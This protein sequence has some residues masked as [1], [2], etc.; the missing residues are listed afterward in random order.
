MECRPAL[1]TGLSWIAAA[2]TAATLH[3][4]NANGEPAYPERPVRILVPFPPGQTVDIVG[5]IIGE[6]FTDAFGKQ[7][8]VDNRAGAGGTIGTALAARAVPDGYTLVVV[9]NGTLAGNAALW[10]DKL[11]YKATKDFAPIINF[12]A[13]PQL[14]VSSP[15]SPYKTVQDLVS[16]AKANPGKLNY[17]LPG[18]GNSSHLAMEM[19]RARAGIDINPVPYNGSPA[20]FIDIMAGRI[21]VMFEAASGVLV[22]VKSGKI[23]AIATGGP[24]RAVFLPDV[25][26]VAESGYPG[27][28]A[29][30]WVGLAAPAGTPKAIVNVLYHE[31]DK[32]L[33]TPEGK[34]RIISMGMEPLGMDPQQ[35][36]NH[37]ATE[38][39]RWTKV[40]DDAGIKLE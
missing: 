31:A 30:P 9:S 3:I 23:R 40:V 36:G 19:L 18:V 1:A 7:F 5:R 15:S 16:Y 39:D 35:F 29:V 21:P 11:P 4:T 14:L 37:I 22:H 25:P 12:I 38:V 24:A 20:A 34:S 26:T 10:K 6:R 13:T 8:I 27:F 32:L 33:Q 28:S 2:A 17:A